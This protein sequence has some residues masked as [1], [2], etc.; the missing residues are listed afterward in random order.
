MIQNINKFL[1]ENILEF[2]SIQFEN[3]KVTHHQTDN[4]LCALPFLQGNFN[5]PQNI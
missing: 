1:A 4:A 2:S 5:T 3:Y